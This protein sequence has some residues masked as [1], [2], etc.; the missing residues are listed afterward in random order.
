MSEVD[1][2]LERMAMLEQHVTKEAEQVTEDVEGAEKVLQQHCGLEEELKM[3]S[4][5]VLKA[6][7]DLISSIEQKPD[8]SGTSSITPDRI[9]ASATIRY[10]IYSANH[11][12]YTLM[13]VAALCRHLLDAIQRR[14]RQLE[15]L[16]RNY[17]T[18]LEQNLQLKIFERSVYKVSSDLGLWCACIRDYI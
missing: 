10:N 11:L 5:E 9:N 2:L 8:C 15:E 16:W 3:C 13:G 18:Q 1:A 17:K 14:Q 7:R 4:Q 12:S 6:G